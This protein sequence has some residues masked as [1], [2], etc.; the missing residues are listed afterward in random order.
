MTNSD[1][2]RSSTAGL[3]PGTL[4]HIGRKRADK[5]RI[6][7][8]NYDERHFEEK[9][10][11]RA[12]DVAAFKDKMNVT[13]VNV[14]GLHD[15]RVVEELGSIFGLHNLTLEDILNTGHR[16]KRDDLG[17]YILVILKVL[18]YEEMGGGRAA[19]QISLVLGRGFVISFQERPNKMFDPIRAQIRS[20]QGLVRKS[21]ADYLA[22]RL[23]DT[24]VDNY[25]TVVEKLGERIEELEDSLVTD[26]RAQ[27]LQN[28]H[29][30]KRETILLR[31]A[32]WPMRE[33][34]SELERAESPLIN[35]STAMYF[36]DIYDHVFEVIDIVETYRDMSSGMLD[37]YLSSVS[38]RL[39]AVMKV[40]TIVAT[41][42]IPLTFIV[43]IYGMNFKYMPELEWQW[44]YPAVLLAIV[45]IVA[46][47][48]LTFKKKGWM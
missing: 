39:N 20:G 19:E 27:T 37:I 1:E 36:R 6:V 41:I 35:R 15:V 5:V 47:M 12:E 18:A 8:S 13:W 40:L 42:F 25:F 21:G 30:L 3:L 9:E 45:M 38:N 16:P 24:V 17:D 26:P 43:G 46:G 23:I 2:K 33:V 4:V 28:M 29:N 22:Y 48:L 44:G 14:D 11:R 7:V 34:V 32:V 31:Q 10:V